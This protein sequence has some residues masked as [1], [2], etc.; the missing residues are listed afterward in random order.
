MGSLLDWAEKSC[1]LS[2]L[3][4]VILDGVCY[5]PCFVLSLCFF[6]GPGDMQPAVD[7]DGIPLGAVVPRLGALSGR[8]ASSV[9]AGGSGLDLFEPC[10]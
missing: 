7:Q 3:L 8:V 4:S 9:P 2:V 1:S 10:G 5:V 6:V